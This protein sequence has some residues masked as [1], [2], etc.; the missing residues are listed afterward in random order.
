M[1]DQI[2]AVI[3][4]GVGFT[5]A[6]LFA[7]IGENFAERSGVIVLAVEGELLAS[8]FCSFIV[9][10]LTK[11]IL[12]GIA[13]G[14]LIAALVAL[15][16]AFASI[17]LGVDQI[18]SSIGLNMVVFGA[19]S[20]FFRQIFWGKANVFTLP[21]IPVLNKIAIPYLSQLPVVAPV[22]FNQNILTYLALLMVPLAALILYRTN[23]G[24]NIR[25]VGE[26][27]DAALASGIN[28]VI[29]R[30]SSVIIGGVLAGLGGIALTL[31]ETGIFM[32]GMSAGRGFLA[33]SAVIFGNWKPANILIG[34]M[35]FGII[36]S[37]QTFLQALGSP[38]PY[39]FMQMLP[40]ITCILALALATNKATVPVS[41]G[42]PFRK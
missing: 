40:Y 5:T 37:I 28:I 39:Q 3:A 34:A 36:G 10:S 21:Q 25:S 42:I 30:Y 19:T 6:I 14:I 16:H 29:T 2:V 12:L 4:S 15:I 35:L 24:L 26:D 23:F 22:F 7:A 32:D 18:V 8:A 13:A 27:P 38:I 20:F 17:T 33:V 31:G 41:L 1:V 11:N 9:V